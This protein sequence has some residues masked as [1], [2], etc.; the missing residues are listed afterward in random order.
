V[1][2]MHKLLYFMVD[3]LSKFNK[4]SSIHLQMLRFL[5]LVISSFGS[6][7]EDMEN[8]LKK[9]IEYNVHGIKEYFED[10]ALWESSEVN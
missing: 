9:M 7:D 2:F 1:D 6:Q 8:S 10:M 4:S 5:R 3:E